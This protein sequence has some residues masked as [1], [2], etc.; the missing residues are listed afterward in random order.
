MQQCCLRYELVC[1]CVGDS[2]GGRPSQP[3]SYQGSS[4]NMQLNFQLLNLTSTIQT[5]QADLQF[6]EARVSYTHIQSSI[7]SEARKFLIWVRFQIWMCSNFE[8]SIWTSE[9]FGLNLFF[10]VSGKSLTKVSISRLLKPFCRFAFGCCKRM[11]SIR[12]SSKS[13][14]R[15]HTKDSLN[16]IYIQEVAKEEMQ[17][18]EG[19]ICRVDVWHQAQ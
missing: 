18:L 1:T 5:Q 6:Y 10:Q 2:G 11:V 17:E 7:R 4:S 14:I 19:L 9:T 13:Y 12:E 3:P 16:C 8:L 15:M